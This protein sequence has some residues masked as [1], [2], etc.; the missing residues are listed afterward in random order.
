MNAFPSRELEGPVVTRVTGP[1][2]LATV[3]AAIGSLT[4]G[5]PPLPHDADGSPALPHT[6][7]VPGQ[8]MNATGRTAADAGVTL[9][10]HGGGFEQHNPEFE[11]VMAYWL[12]KATGRPV[13][14]VD[15]RLAPAHPFPAAHDDVLGAYRSLLDQDVPASRL[16]LLGESAGGTLVLS[17][18]H[19]MRAERIPF[20][21]GVVA[22]SAITDLTLSGR[23][24]DAPAADDMLNRP[25][26]ERIVAQY[27]NGAAP[28]QAPQS[29]LHGD[30]SGLPPSLIVVGAGEVLLDDSHGYAHAAAA[31]GTP[32][33]LDVYEGMP[34][35]F[36][37]SLLTEP[38]PAVATIF[39]ERLAAWTASL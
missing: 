3:V 34:H 20:P 39:L 8:W 33:A 29:P 30:L 37:V 35:A 38:Q 9:Y 12:S 21:S 24:I 13:F 36:H 10:V 6:G 25:V 2:D 5:G 11:R 28:D 26:L 23:S 16:V 17:A 14:A 15:Y 22:V 7:G 18:L 4:A 1:D 32:V 27:L 31:A 19:T